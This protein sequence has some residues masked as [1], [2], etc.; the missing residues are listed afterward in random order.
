MFHPRFP[1]VSCALLLCSR[2]LGAEP[3]VSAV[4]PNYGTHDG[5]V[6]VIITGT[7]FAP[8]ATVTIGGQPASSVTV[9][10]G[11]Q[12]TIV[13]PARASSHPDWPLPVEVHASNP[14]GS[15]VT[16]ANGF[17]Y[18][19]PIFIATDC[20]VHEFLVGELLDFSP[21]DPANPLT[22]LYDWGD[23]TIDTVGSHVYT[24][25]G[26]YHYQWTESNGFYTGTGSVAFALLGRATI[27]ALAKT[28]LFRTE[29]D[30][31]VVTV[32]GI[33][34]LYLTPS[35]PEDFSF[36]GKYFYVM[37][38]ASSAGVLLSP[39]GTG[40]SAGA[41]ARLKLTADG[42]SVLFRMRSKVTYPGDS[43][44]LK[45]KQYWTDRVR[46]TLGEIECVADVPVVS[47][48]RP[49]GSVRVLGPRTGSPHP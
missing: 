26:G 29:R 22:F 47:R 33:L 32:S 44:Q 16:L 15:H 10:S 21:A 46:I 42:S 35:A 48:V 41:R 1:H 40:K 12:I 30:K 20:I 23:G 3:S 24:R 4:T 39:N 37:A 2:L 27:S 49:N 45:G 43:S 36:A 8:G 34:P 6:T 5:G 11:T 7:G 9:I 38:G 31:G 25:P 14:D 19:D 28:L 13:T 18:V 17:T